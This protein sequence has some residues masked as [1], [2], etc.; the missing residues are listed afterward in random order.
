MQSH[1]VSQKDQL[2]R[3]IFFGSSW[4]LVVVVVSFQDYHIWHQLLHLLWTSVELPSLSS[5]LRS[6]FS[7]L[8]SFFSFFFSSFSFSS[9]CERVYLLIGLRGLVVRYLFVVVSWCHH[10]HHTIL[11]TFSFQRRFLWV[12]ITVISGFNL[13]KKKLRP[14]KVHG[15]KKKPYKNQIT[16]SSLFLSSSY[17]LTHWNFKTIYIYINTKNES[18]YYM[19]LWYCQ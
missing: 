11:I 7:L 19:T 14:Y 5:Y 17:S 10:H 6:L 18:N 13:K 15:K 4:V 3:H 1:L 16:L 9:F 12:I 2:L 8:S